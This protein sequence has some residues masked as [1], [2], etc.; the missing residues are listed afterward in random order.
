MADNYRMDAPRVPPLRQD[1]RQRVVIHRGIFLEA[2]EAQAPETR[3][4]LL[5]ALHDGTFNRLHRTVRISQSDV[6]WLRLLQLLFLKLGRRSWIYRE[7]RS[8]NVWVVEATRRLDGGGGLLTFRDKVAFVRGYFDAEGG[9]PRRTE[10]R[11]Y[12]QITQ[13]DRLDLEWVRQLLE[14]LDIR[15]GKVH[16]PSVRVDPTIG[17]CMS[18]LP[19]MT[20]LS[21][22]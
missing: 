19:R 8:R 6:R 5:G 2:Q 4:Y 18:L 9:V 11:F 13:K 21:A 17:D 3:A 22:A 16:N 15:C 10:D 7:G 14:A 1:V 12:I 20:P